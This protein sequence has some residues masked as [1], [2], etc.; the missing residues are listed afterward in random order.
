MAGT[1]NQ[2]RLLGSVELEQDGRIY[3]G[4]RTYYIE[5]GTV[6]FLDSPKP[7]PEL[8]IHAYTR[9]GDYTVNLGLTGATETRLPPLSPRIRRCPEMTSSRSC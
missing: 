9:A 1:I 6:R 4:D 8:D 5:R 7:I 3:F 2:P